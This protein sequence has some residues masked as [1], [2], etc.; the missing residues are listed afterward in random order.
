MNGAIRAAVLIKHKGKFLLVQEGHARAR[1]LWN[2]QQGKVEG[3]ESIEDAAVREAK[4]ETGYDVSIVRKLGVIEKP[5]PDTS[6]IHVFLGEITGGELKI[7]GGEVIEARWFAQD[8]LDELKDRAPGPWIYEILA[9][10][11]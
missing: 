2:W 6:E 3:D 11:V 8:D 7:P 10:L 4:E 1:G 5:F 9:S